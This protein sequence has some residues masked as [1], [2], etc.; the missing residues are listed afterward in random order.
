MITARRALVISALLQV[1]FL[2]L[3]LAFG[4]HSAVG[5]VGEAFYA[6]LLLFVKY[7]PPSLAYGGVFWVA[8]LFTFQLLLVGTIVF[9]V[10]ILKMHLGAR[11]HLPR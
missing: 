4:P 5:A 9:I 1:P 3:A 2:F 10:L 7:L 6:P 11:M 8:F